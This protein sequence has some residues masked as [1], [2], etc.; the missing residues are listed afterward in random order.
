MNQQ[1]CCKEMVQ[2]IRTWRQLLDFLPLGC[3]RYRFCCFVQLSVFLLA[4]LS[5][6]RTARTKVF[7]PMVPASMVVVTKTTTT[8]HGKAAV[9]CN[10]S[11]HSN[12]ISMAVVRIPSPSLRITWSL[13]TRTSLARLPQ[14]VGSTAPATYVFS[15]IQKF[16]TAYLPSVC[17]DLR[18]YHH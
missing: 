14:R 1:V 2:S 9:S 12:G 16:S 5:Y 3:Y 15:Q 13:D 8:L 18:R 11:N 10:G 4:L 17:S 7:C 6:I